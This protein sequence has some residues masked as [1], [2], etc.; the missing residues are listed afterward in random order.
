MLKIVLIALPSIVVLLLI[1]IAFQPSAFRITRS[2]RF[3]A[4]PATVFD[5]INNFHNWAAWSPWARLDPDARNHF[6]GPASGT[7]AAFSWAGNSKVGEGHMRITDSRPS[8]LI[9]IDLVFL[10]PF[11]ATNITEFTFRPDGDGIAVTW[12]MSGKNSFMGKAAGLFMNCDKMV[13]GQF[14]Q[15]LANLE[16]VVAKM[17]ARS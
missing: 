8:E 5:Q 12:T 6:D 14:E 2:A 13:G 9:L 4:P 15:G 10:K 1:V 3:A 7:G 11:A 17:A 16:L